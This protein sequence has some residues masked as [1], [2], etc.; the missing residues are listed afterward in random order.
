MGTTDCSH[1]QLHPR[2]AEH[3]ATSSIPADFAARA[4]LYS[5]A[6]P[7]ELSRLLGW[8]KPA[9]AL[10]AAIVIPFDSPSSGRD[11]YCRLRPDIP[12]EIT[13]DKPDGRV[14]VAKYEAPKGSPARV[15]APTWVFP[16]IADPDTP[17]MIVEGEK[18]CLALLANNVAT[19]AL[20]GV[21]Q[22]TTTATTAD[23]KTT[24]V[25]HPELAR[26]AVAGRPV[27]VMFDADADDN[28]Q[29]IA[30]QARLV[31]ALVDAGCRPRVIHLPGATAAG[32][33]A[34]GIDDYITAAGWPEVA[35][36][37]GR[38][39]V[40]PIT[41]DGAERWPE[42]DREISTWRL[43]RLWR[44]L[45]TARHVRN[46]LDALAELLEVDAETV[47]G[48]A[49]LG[50]QA[51][52][53]TE[54]TGY[55]LRVERGVR[56]WALSDG[57]TIPAGMDALLAKSGVAAARYALARWARP[58]VWNGGH[59]WSYEAGAW[60]PVDNKAMRRH[61]ASID[62]TPVNGSAANRLSIGS[63]SISDVLGCLE[64]ELGAAGEILGRAHGVAFADRSAILTAD[65]GL[66][67]VDHDPAH[68]LQTWIDGPVPD[69][70]SAPLW[71]RQLDTVVGPE[72]DTTIEEFVGIALAGAASTYQKALWLRGGAGCGKSVILKTI[73]SLWPRE[74][75]EA[76][77]IS[78]L[79]HEYTRAQV[80]GKRLVY[81]T[82]ADTGRLDPAAL[83]AVQA[84]ITGDAVGA[85]HPAGRPFSIESDTA[86]AWCSNELPPAIDR[87]GAW[88]RRILLI[89]CH[90]RFADR[91]G[92]VH[93]Y[94][95]RLKAESA[96]IVLRGL[97]AAAAMIARGGTYTIPPAMAASLQQWAVDSDPL[98]AWI[99]EE[100]IELSATERTSSS[101]AYDE[102]RDW[103]NR[104]GHRPTSTRVW[105]SRL[106]QMGAKRGRDRNCRWVGL[107]FPT[108]E[109]DLE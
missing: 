36:Y 37:L 35:S 72:A 3:L 48:W 75:V 26:Y 104:T 25:L 62:Q 46:K 39:R 77:G 16:E 41:G 28:D 31:Q 9:T 90:G 59:Y 54:C 20:P 24:H 64:D 78:A 88:S 21:W 89:D 101:K 71:S 6:D 85:R 45:Y 5:E 40:D 82:E 34:K 67:I 13:S 47:R 33:P 108:I 15:Y 83:S 60:R 53:E 38:H 79:G 93:R 97:R 49:A 109:I 22:G 63:G 73:A 84:M 94:E 11:G 65:G 1:L 92:E 32:V 44:V 4:G 10:G 30:A 2:H 61:V 7:A 42:A 70:D 69:D 23:G 14:R 80:A 87:H 100:S 12:R 98:L 96:A 86:F 29:V 107:R 51:T 52:G 27:T 19:V 18:K 81:S 8:A 103:C 66:Q 68:G 95:D 91:P 17:L 43:T 55:T 99:D 56:V 50:N 102:Y 105:A 57:T 58:L 106:D 74:L 76:Y